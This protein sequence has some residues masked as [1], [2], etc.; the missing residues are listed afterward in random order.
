MVGRM[1][2]TA[3]LGAIIGWVFDDRIPSRG[4]VINTSDPSVADPVKAA[5]FFEMYESAE[6]RFVDRYLRRD[7]DTVELGGSLGYVS[8]LI[9]RRL[10]ANAKLICVEANPR[11]IPIL[12]QNL[13]INV[14]GSSTIVV[15]AAVDGPG[16]R[17]SRFSI[18]KDN[19]V[20]KIASDNE[21]SL[22]VP[23]MGLEQLLSAHSIPQYTLVS[24]I[25]GSEASFIFGAV[26]PLVGCQQIVIELHDTQYE[27]R[28]ISVEELRAALVERHG[29]RV[30]DSYGPVYFFER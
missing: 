2:S 4:L 3:P 27:G 22:L 1:L 13:S 23:S 25:E 20:S 30:V 9:R 24:D 26:E 29:F 6:F 21:A 14:P 19:L 7:L 10:A 5:L 16:L 15:N 28:R 17:H 12:N 11:L 18:G 8:C